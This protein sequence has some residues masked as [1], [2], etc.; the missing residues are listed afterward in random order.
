MVR[1]KSG[2]FGMEAYPDFRLTSA[3]SSLFM[4]Y[5]FVPITEKT[6]EAVEKAMLDREEE[7]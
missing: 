4:G 6:R 5:P 1:V 7:K 2:E 3:S